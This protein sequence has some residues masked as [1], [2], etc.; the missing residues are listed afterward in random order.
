MA[1]REWDAILTHCIQKAFLGRA[2]MNSKVGGW[3]PLHEGFST[4]GEM[5]MPGD[6]FGGPNCREGDTAMASRTSDAGENPTMPRLVPQQEL[7]CP[8][9]Q[10]FQ[11]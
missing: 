8:K 5:A 3:L 9:C 2:V 11:G 1:P 7:C 6:N 4:R 10:Q